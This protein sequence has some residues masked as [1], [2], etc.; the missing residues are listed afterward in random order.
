MVPGAQL[1]S[2]VI[3]AYSIKLSC[4]AGQTVTNGLCVAPST[5]APSTT[6]KASSSAMYII[7]NIGLILAV[8]VLILS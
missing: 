7:L 6:S 4:P 8:M 2:E 5:V 3:K 1:T